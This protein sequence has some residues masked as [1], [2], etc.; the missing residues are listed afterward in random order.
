MPWMPGLLITIVRTP[1][2]V[3]TEDM[4]EGILAVYVLVVDVVDI[5][6]SALMDA[7]GRAAETVKTASGMD[8]IDVLIPYIVDIL[9]AGI[10][11]FTGVSARDVPANQVLVADIV[12]LS[13]EIE[14][15]GLDAISI[16]VGV[17]E[18]VADIHV[19]TSDE[20]ETVIFVAVLI[21]RRTGTYDMIVVDFGIA[22]VVEEI[23]PAVF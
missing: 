18:A 5:R 17:T 10:T 9:A 21:G 16:V 4:L 1:E 23:D 19:V 15:S 11:Y 22:A 13:I 7:D 12:C 6:T 20:V 2:S 8:G 14:G 3:D